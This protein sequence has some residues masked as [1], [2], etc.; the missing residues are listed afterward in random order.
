MFGRGIPGWGLDFF[1]FFLRVYLF[2]HER[3]TERGSD[4]GGGR[5][6]LL[7]GSPMR[8]SSP[9]VG[10]HPEPKADAQPVNHTGAPVLDF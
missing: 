6:R 8:D 9:G 5:S 1:F 2:I 10:S 4:I 7:T 3:H